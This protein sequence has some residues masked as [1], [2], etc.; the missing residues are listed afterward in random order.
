[1]QRVPSRSGPTVYVDYAHTPDALKVALKALRQHCA[2]R[3]WCVF[4]CGGDR[5][6]GKRPQMGQVA[7]ELADRV[8]LTNDNPRSESPAAIIENILAGVRDVPVEVIEDRLAAIAW[9]IAAAGS[10]DTILI[11]GKGH[12]NYQVIGTE[13]RAFSDY[14][15]AAMSLGAGEAEA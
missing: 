9:A 8:V 11:A 13:R 2:G 15:A 5:D 14:E 7:A 3:L 4:G 10:D 12:E 6:A 1:M